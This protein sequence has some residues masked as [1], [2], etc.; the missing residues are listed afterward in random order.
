MDNLRKEEVIQAVLIADSYNDNFQ[1]IIK[2][3]NTVNWTEQMDTNWIVVGKL[4]FND[5]IIFAESFAAGQY[6]DDRLCLG[7][8]E[9]IQSCRSV[10]VLHK[11]SGRSE[12]SYQVSWF[13]TFGKQRQQQIART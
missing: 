9:Q 8:A 2:D 1:P 6:A 4:S 10:S 5:M 12:R 3:G 13:R 11:S 7:G